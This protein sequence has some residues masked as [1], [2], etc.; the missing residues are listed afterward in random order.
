[1]PVDFGYIII[2]A[3][4]N[5]IT[6]C[7]V[8]L[9][10]S[11][12]VVLIINIC[13]T[14]NSISKLLSDITELPTTVYIELVYIQNVVNLKHTLLKKLATYSV[15]YCNCIIKIQYYKLLIAAS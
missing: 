11:Q 6:A 2:F 4:Q 7:T 9:K 14:N 13:I 3:I 10:G 15:Q 5:S 1:M 8:Y 12:V